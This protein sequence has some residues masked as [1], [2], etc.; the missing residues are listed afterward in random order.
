MYTATNFP[1]STDAGLT[2]F[3]PDVVIYN[4]EL[5]VRVF[6]ISVAVA[7]AISV[8][9]RLP[10]T[11]VTAPSGATFATVLFTLWPM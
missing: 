2:N 1:P 5:P 3:L 9:F 7:A 10:A 11:I 6:P 8:E 4:T